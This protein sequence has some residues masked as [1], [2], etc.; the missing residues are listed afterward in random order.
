MRKVLLFIIREIKLNRYI[1][2]KYIN[3]DIYI[4]KY[5]NIDNKFIKVLFKYIIFIINNL[6]IKIF[7]NINIFIYKDIDLIIFT[8]INY[9][10][11][12]YIL[13]NF[14][15]ILFIRSFIK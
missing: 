15:I 7:I 11:N 5:Y 6:K 9:I 13:F 8:R 4:L 3:L 10:D 12:Y 2:I 14:N 1:M